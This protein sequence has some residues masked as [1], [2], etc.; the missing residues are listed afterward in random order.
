MYMSRRSPMQALH[1]PGGR[2]PRPALEARTGVSAGIAF[3]Q[4]LQPCLSLPGF[5]GVE[6]LNHSEATALLDT[7]VVLGRSIHTDSGRVSYEPKM[8]KF[9]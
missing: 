6:L 9:L 3:R 4:R 7:L 1:P 5:G 2:H 8:A